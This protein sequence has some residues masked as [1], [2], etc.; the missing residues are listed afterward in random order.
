MSV[1]FD[2]FKTTLFIVRS[3]WQI[4]PL[5]RSISIIAVE[6]RTADNLNPKFRIIACYSCIYILRF[7]ARA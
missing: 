7:Y 4:D 1:S 6:F 3:K 5:P 2:N